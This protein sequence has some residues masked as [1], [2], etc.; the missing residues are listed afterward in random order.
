M[1]EISKPVFF[2]QTALRV[3]Q[4]AMS[5]LSVLYYENDFRDWQVDGLMSQAANRI[6]CL[7]ERLNQIA[8]EEMGSNEKTN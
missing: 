4:E 6:G 5:C 1:G 3:V 7:Y 2:M 8:K